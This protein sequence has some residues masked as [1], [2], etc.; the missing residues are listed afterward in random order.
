[1]VSSEREEK[2]HSNLSFT[3]SLRKR[4]MPFVGGQ[5]LWRIQNKS[6]APSAWQTT[7]PKYN[8]DVHV[9][10]GTEQLEVVERWLFEEIWPFLIHLARFAWKK[11]LNHYHQPS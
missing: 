1:M 4:K 8:N 6:S 2:K 9:S 3:D 7:F 11:E 10:S 5:L